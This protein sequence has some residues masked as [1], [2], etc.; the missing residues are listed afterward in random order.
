M[1]PMHML[2]S[3]IAAVQADSTFP[4]SEDSSTWVMLLD[5]LLAEGDAQPPINES[6]VHIYAELARKY[7]I[8]GLHFCCDIFVSERKFSVGN[9]LRWYKLADEY[10]MDRA[11]V[12]CHAF[13]AD[14]H[15]L[16]M[17][18]CLLR[19]PNCKHVDGCRGAG[20]PFMLL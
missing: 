12:V 8:S 11:C 18:R 2:R 3:M 6:N 5:A 4:V 16:E 13:V 20:T 7:D 17:D 10:R 1:I 9:L 19:T 15:Y 14:G